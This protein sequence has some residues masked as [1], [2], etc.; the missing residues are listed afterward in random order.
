MMNKSSNS[1]SILIGSILFLALIMITGIVI[2]PVLDEGNEPK[3]ELVKKGVQSQSNS[4]NNGVG[5]EGP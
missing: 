4:G 3:L 2:L 5:Q 1:N